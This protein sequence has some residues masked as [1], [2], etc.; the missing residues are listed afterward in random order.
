MRLVATRVSKGFAGVRALADVDFDLNA[1]EVHA[2][3]GEN[4]AGKSTLVKVLGGA[5]RPDAG[6]AVLDG[7]P[8]PFGDPLEARRRGLSLVYQELALAPHLS[9]ADNVFLGR[10]RGRLWL[11]R[12]D[13]RRAVRALLDELGADVDPD[14]PARTLSVGYQQMVEIARALATEARVL[15]LDEATAALSAAEVERLFA[16]VRRLRAR[17]LGIVFVSHRLD[18][19]LAVADRVTVLRDGRRVASAA[20]GDVDR[21]RL[22]RWM[23]GRDLTEEFPVR[24]PAPGAT[25]LDVRGLKAPPRLHDASLS[26]RAGE[27]VG[28][29]GLVGAGRSSAAL[30][31]VGARRA[32]GEIR[33][34]GQRVHFRSPAEAIAHGVVYVT[35]DR[36]ARGLWPQMSAEANLTLASLGRLTRFGLLSRPRERTLAAEA[37]R[38][39]DVR[40]ASLAQPAAALSGGNQQ[41]LLL[42]RFLLE[43]RRLVVLDEPTRGV[44]VGARAEIYALIARLAAE[45]A[46]ILLISSDLTEVLGLAD[47][48]V[49]MRDG[50]TVGTLVRAE[51]TP[52][53]VMALATTGRAA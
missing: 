46:A 21:A 25:V 7:A 14:A 11:R 44:D 3:V 38:R 42:A 20:A 1:G 4:G 9:V 10:E 15:M 41:K 22:I 23:V 33:L 24:A 48:I 27:I 32:T 36:Q 30:A 17:G 19:V 39:F 34:D 45:G 13:M 26:V 12:A 35:E 6:E 5:V 29:A 47:R 49:V 16:V 18:E 31:L 28:L 52:E 37:A 50:R 2:L 40:A 8:L 43:P 53:R 51:A